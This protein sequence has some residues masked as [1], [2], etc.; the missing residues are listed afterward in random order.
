MVLPGIGYVS[1]TVIYGILVAIA[2]SAILLLGERKTRQGFSS[3][4]G[5]KSPAPVT[6]SVGETTEKAPAKETSS[7]SD[8]IDWDNL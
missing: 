5:Q 6:K 1:V 4:G 7:G 8:E 3:G 2:I